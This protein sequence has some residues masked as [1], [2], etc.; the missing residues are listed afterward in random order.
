VSYYLGVDGGGT[1]TLA[2]VTDEYGMVIGVG[3]GGN[4]N[5]QISRENA[6]AALKKATDEALLSSG[7]E[8]SMLSSSCFGLA[9]ADTTQ[10]IV[11]IKSILRKLGFENC[12]IYNDG[13]IALKAADASFFGMTLICG[14]ATNAIGRDH[15]GNIH[16]VGGFGYNFGDFGGGH[17]LSKEIF[18]L[19]I[20]SAEGREPKTLLSDLVLNELGFKHIS[21][22]Y[23]Y[24]LI[25]KKSI[26]VHLTPLL[27]EAGE[28]GDEPAIR[29]IEK[30]A[31]ELVLSAE[32]LAGKMKLSAKPFTLVLAGSVITKSK[33]D[34][35]YHAFLSKLRHS[36]LNANVTKL[37]TE[38]VIGSALLA[39]GKNADNG[40][41]KQHLMQSLHS[42]MKGSDLDG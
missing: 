10:D 32:A 17:H 22:M 14:T 37:K 40:K 7:I 23:E 27:F 29:L 15:E 16:Q 11:I 5:H 28:Q 6:E 21:E 18:R 33:R 2:I 41:V 34:L 13:L 3:A 9:G 26:P 35:M 30:Q 1:K 4:S 38:P 39:I 42:A 20:R 8:Q 24:Y 19:V 25:N 36:H 31:A 12:M